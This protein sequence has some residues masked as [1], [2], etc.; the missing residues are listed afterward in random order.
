MPKLSLA[1]FKPVALD[2]KEYLAK[3]KSR[4]LAPDG[5]QV[6]DP[7]PIAPP[8]GYKKQPSMVEIVR[9]M[10]RSERLK[11]EAEQAGME[12]FEE[13]EDFEVGD[14]PFEE[15]KSGFE[16]DYDPPIR[17]IVEEV[18]KAR[19]ARAPKPD[20]E[21]KEPGVTGDKSPV[22]KPPSEEP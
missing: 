19:K 9:E 20:K 16:N 1:R 3:L 11:Q 10:V 12:T 7:T 18:D 4:G 14:E 13:S 21:P 5:R 17:E 15:L 22:A 2:L 6:P 8:I